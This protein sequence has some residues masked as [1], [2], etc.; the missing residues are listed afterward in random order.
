M[1][2]LI[3]TTL[4]ILTSINIAYEVKRAKRIKRANTKLDSELYRRKD[5]ENDK[6]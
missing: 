6:K 5:K 1:I 3:I 4:L 2:Y